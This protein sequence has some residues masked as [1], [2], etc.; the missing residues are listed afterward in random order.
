MPV[1]AVIKRYFLIYEKVKHSYYPSLEAISS[2]LEEEGFGLSNRTIQ[3][4]IA[5]LRNEFGIDILYDPAQ[6]GYHLGEENLAGQD[7][8]IRLLEIMTT[9]GMIADT[10]KDGKDALQYLSFEGSG[11]MK[12]I[13][14]LDKILMAIRERQIITFRHRNFYTGQARAVTFK[15]YLLKEYRQRWYVIGIGSRITYTIYGLDRISGLEVTGRHFQRD[16]HA[17]P[18]DLFDNIIGI[19]YDEH[20]PEEIILSFTPQQGKY[21]K[22]LPIHT[23]Q[24]ILTDDDNELRI[25]LYLR[26]NFELTQR[27]LSYGSQV[28]VMAPAWLKREITAVYKAALRQYQ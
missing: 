19:N 1:Q 4:D 27:L 22:T 24:R 11:D 3:R 8:F 6:N 26:P 9:A 16:E 15:P 5:Q 10:L 21:I 7:R 17:N 25:S 18:A 12:G 2:Y 13:Q 14:Y 20:E 28:K 23:S